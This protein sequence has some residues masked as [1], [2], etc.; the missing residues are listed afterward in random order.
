MRRV[1]YGLHIGEVNDQCVNVC[2]LMYGL[3]FNRIVRIESALASNVSSLRPRNTTLA[4]RF[5]S[6][7]AAASTNIS[8]RSGNQY[9]L[10]IRHVDTSTETELTRDS[11]WRVAAKPWSV[12]HVG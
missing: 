11:K 10:L 6:E 2:I 8:G 1:S 4:P 5:A 7:T 9:C 12:F 3:C